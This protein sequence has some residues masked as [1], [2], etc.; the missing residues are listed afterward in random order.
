MVDN[1]VQFLNDQRT[2]LKKNMLGEFLQNMI[3]FFS[4]LSNS[5]MMQ[6]HQIASKQFDAMCQQAGQLSAFKLL[7]K[8]NNLPTQP[9]N[10]ILLTEL[11]C[12]GGHVEIVRDILRK[13]ELPILLLATNIN[14]RKLP[15]LQS[16][17]DEENVLGMIDANDA[18]YIE[19]LRSTQTVLTNSHVNTIFILVHGYDAVGV[20]AI[21][22][23]SG[24][25]ILF[26]HHC[27]H[28]PTLGCYL[29]G[30]HHIDLH[31]VGFL[32]CRNEFNI[33]T[34]RYLCLSSMNLKSK[35]FDKTF[36]NPVFKTASCGGI[37]KMTKLPYYISYKDVVLH[38]LN[39]REGV[40]FHIGHLSDEYLKNIYNALEH[41][42]LSDDQFIYLGEVPNLAEILI[43]LEV[44]VYFP[45][46][47]QSGGKAL[48]D[49]MA[50]GIPI[51]T[52]QNARDR[53]WGSIDL[54]YPTALTWATF[55]ELDD[56][57]EKYD[58]AFWQS[59]ANESRAYYDRFHSE[60]LFL[61]HLKRGGVDIDSDDIPKLKSYQPDV[62]RNL[63]YLGLRQ[64]SET[65]MK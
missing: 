19:K 53:L 25:N 55:D 48:I 50:A 51:L 29:E 5:P 26:I 11:H 52:H 30:A 6:G 20:S 3:H 61:N 8:M 60:A 22:P 28:S 63:M 21:A 39:K 45:T 64:N 7:R 24:K 65:S 35:R 36:A 56:A 4:E 9:H 33:T 10:V 1:V 12:L 54:I 62:A 59:Q 31:N 58:K 17:L 14:S 46:L 42:G 40:H 18:T 13:S 41:L 34:N 44:D 15:I 47:P 38:V 43:Q 49:V 2:A 27:D 23:N 16:I 57:L 32:R 37:H